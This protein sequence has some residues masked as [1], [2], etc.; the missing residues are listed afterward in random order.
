MYEL[1]SR[2]RLMARNDAIASLA[3]KVDSDKTDDLKLKNM[4]FDVLDKVNKN[5][6]FFT[7]FQVFL[8]NSQFYASR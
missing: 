8:L 1:H 4:F 2:K 5:F 6:T 3:K 7:S